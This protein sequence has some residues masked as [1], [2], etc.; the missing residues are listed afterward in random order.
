M[1]LGDLIVEKGD[2]KRLHPSG[3]EPLSEGT[4]RKQSRTEEDA[5]YTYKSSNEF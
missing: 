3:A 2:L 5:G 4:P 1:I